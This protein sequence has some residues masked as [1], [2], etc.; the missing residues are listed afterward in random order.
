MHENPKRLVPPC[1]CAWC[2]NW[3]DE[4]DLFLIDPFSEKPICLECYDFVPPAE[5]VVDD[6]DFFG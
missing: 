4:F 2:N 5:R 1:P 6:R 3:I